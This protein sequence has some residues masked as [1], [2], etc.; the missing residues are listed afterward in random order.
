MSLL[1][2]LLRTPEDAWNK[3]W[4][5]SLM[6]KASTAAAPVVDGSFAYVVGTSSWL[7]FLWRLVETGPDTLRLDIGAAAF[8]EAAITILDQLI[9]YDYTSSLARSYDVTDIER[10]IRIRARC[11]VPLLG[12]SSTSIAS[13]RCVIYV[14]SCTRPRSTRPRRLGSCKPSPSSL[15]SI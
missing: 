10:H 12:T 5:A 11:C 3:L 13:Q 6:M 2:A 7:A 9:V 8:A 4:I 14:R 15:A 1:T